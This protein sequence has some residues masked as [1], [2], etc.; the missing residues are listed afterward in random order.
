MEHRF[1]PMRTAV[2]LPPLPR[3]EGWPAE[4]PVL[5]PP[6][7]GEGWGEGARAQSQS[8]TPQPTAPTWWRLTLTLHQGLTVIRNV[9][10]KPDAHQVLECGWFELSPNGDEFAVGYDA[11]ATVAI[12]GFRGPMPGSTGSTL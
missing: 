6:A 7:G 8:A 4:C 2:V 5:L 12:A 1:F 11:I 3:G 9:T 10:T